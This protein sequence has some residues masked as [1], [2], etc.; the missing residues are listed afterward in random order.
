MSATRAQ[1]VE[2]SSTPRPDPARIRPRPRVALT[3]L[4]L[5]SLLVG[6]NLGTPLFPVL[7]HRLGVGPLGI[8]LA[9][10]SYIVALIIGLLVFRCFADSVN[11]R[12]VLVAALTVAATATAALAFAPSLAWFCAGRAAQGAAIACATGTAS[13]ALRILMPTRPGFAGRLTLLASSGGV[14]AGPVVGGALSLAGGDAVAVPFLAVAALLAALIPAILLVAP[15]TA[16][17][18]ATAT[19][20]IALADAPPELD[21]RPESGDPAEVPPTPE[22]PPAPGRRSGHRPGSPA[23][24]AFRVAAATGF[25][26]FTVFGFCLSLAP[27]YFAGIVQ[28]ES[29]LAIGLLSAVTLGASALTQLLPLRGAWRMPVGLSALAVALLGL[30]AAGWIGGAPL[31]VAAGVLAG[32]GQGIAFQAAFT[33]ATT[34]VAPRQHAST[35]SAIYTVTYLGSALPVLGLGALAELVGLGPA[36]AAFA[37]VTAAACAAL[38]FATGGRRAAA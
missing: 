23:L 11:R 5:F 25:L 18:P 30:G 37:L 16:C 26:S 7:E 33:A 10:S 29:R 31:V 6:A 27:S 28:T 38:A 8:S 34:S 36:V 35:V 13:G 14:A 2:A 17:R 24:R 32:A 22:T 3:A 20:P 19:E 12:T 1:A 9:F 21:A 4:A 15:R